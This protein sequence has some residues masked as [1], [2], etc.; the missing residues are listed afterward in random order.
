[1]SGPTRS[2]RQETHPTKKSWD[3]PCHGSRFGPMGKVIAGPATADLPPV[4]TGTALTTALP[5]R[6]QRKDHV[7]SVP[8]RVMMSVPVRFRCALCGPLR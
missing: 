2:L 3:C 7:F 6:A 5:Q 8:G 4:R 1:M